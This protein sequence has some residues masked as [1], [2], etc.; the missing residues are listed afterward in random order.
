[1]PRKRVGLPAFAAWTAGE[2]TEAY[3]I[4]YI[5][6]LSCFSSWRW[7]VSFY[8][9]Y[10]VCLVVLSKRREDREVLLAREPDLS[11]N[12]SSTDLFL[13]R[14]NRLKDPTQKNN[15]FTNGLNLHHSSLNFLSFGS[16]KDNFVAHSGCL[17]R[18]F[19]RMEIDS[20]S[21]IDR[22]SA[23]RTSKSSN[24]ESLGLSHSKLAYDGNFIRSACGM[25]MA[26]EIVSI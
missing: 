16:R 4:G 25:F 14:F 22:S 20:E 15:S 13:N 24:I 19:V 1:L 2:P 6:P 3:R 18:N 26:G 17:F 9:D 8:I 12:E 11:V 5:S 10:T 21:R 7:T 23:D